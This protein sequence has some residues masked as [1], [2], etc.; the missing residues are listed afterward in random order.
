[1]TIL[2]RDIA[3][4]PQRNA[5]ETWK[6]IVELISGSDSED[7]EQLKNVEAVM[8]SLITDEVFA[9]H[10]IV[11][12]GVGPRVKIYTKY[13]FDALE[14]GNDIDRLE[15]N[16]TAGSWKMAVPCDKDNIDWVKKAVEKKS[17]RIEVHLPDQQ[18]DFAGKDDNK[19][20]AE[21]FEINWGALDD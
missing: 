12:A 3:S 5:E 10:P 6:S 21:S 16:P 9:D 18:P 13:Y 4:I 15:N 2:R 17:S 19:T 11:L 7:V 14:A 8:S 1:M 20:S